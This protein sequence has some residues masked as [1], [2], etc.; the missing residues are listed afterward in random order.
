LLARTISGVSLGGKFTG[1]FVMLF[2]SARA[3]RRGLTTSL[4][5]VMAGMGVLLASGLVAVLTASLSKESMESWGWRVPF[6]AGSLIALVALAIRTH[7]L[8]TPLF[9]ELQTRIL[10]LFSARSADFSRMSG[11]WPS[12]R[13]GFRGEIPLGLPSPTAC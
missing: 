12:L 10:G 6:F 13:G 5:N 4:A 2:E 9:E 7:V 1:T 8:E 3:G 11:G